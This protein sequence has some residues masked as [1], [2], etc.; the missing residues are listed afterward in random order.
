M[1]K[2][3]IFHSTLIALVAF[4]TQS[5]GYMEGRP[6][7]FGFSFDIHATDNRDA[8]D[9][10]ETS[11]VDLFLRPYIGYHLDTEATRLRLR[12]EPSL[13][14][15]ED[16]GDDQNEFDLHHRLN[17]EVRQ[18]F[19]ERARARLSNTFFKFDDPEIEEGGAIV[20]TDRSYILNTFRFGFNYDI[21]RLSNL[22]L[23]VRNQIRRYDDSEMA[24]L[25]DKDEIGVGV[26]F[27]HTITPTLIAL[28]HSAYDRYSF[29]DDAFLSRDFD[30]ITGSAGLEYVFLPELI[31]SVSVGAQMRSNDESLLETDENLY[32]EAQLSADTGYNHH[33]GIIAGYGHRDA[34]VAP[35]AT[36][37]YAE[38][39]GFSVASLTQL[40]TLRN[41]ATYRRSSYDTVPEF[42]LPGG[43]EDIFVFDIE[44]SYQITELMSLMVGDRFEYISADDDLS[45]SYTRNTLRAGM[46][47]DF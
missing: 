38:I 35:Y 19:T 28:F 13:R 23:S 20:R 10:G 8:V 3:I 6:V 36:Q 30:S 46:R 14:Y 24:L 31:G 29:E 32:V 2:K 5:Y 11:N 21:G 26:A 12:Y 43:N 34:D 22:D 37:E 27:R 4:A 42:F 18:Q 25:S 1:S 17:V 40:L 44:L 41:A 9:T 33:M 47:M 39:R 16:P 15:R 7:R 45:G